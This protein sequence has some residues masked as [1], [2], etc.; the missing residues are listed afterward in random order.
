MCECAYTH[1]LHNFGLHQAN[2]YVHTMYSDNFHCVTM[3][4]KSIIAHNDLTMHKLAV[5]AGSDF[6]F[7]CRN[8]KRKTL[9]APY[10][11]VNFQPCHAEQ[12]YA[13]KDLIIYEK[14]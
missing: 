8:K 4:F 10:F 14:T 9:N 7:K 12:V 11:F 1:L 6:F 5:V 3:E 2:E 13:S